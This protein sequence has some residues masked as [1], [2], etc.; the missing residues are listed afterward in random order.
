MLFL[1]CSKSCNK[2]GRNRDRRSH[3]NLSTTLSYYMHVMHM[4]CKHFMCACSKTSKNKQISARN[5]AYK[6]NLCHNVDTIP[7]WLR[8]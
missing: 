4:E 7:A 5:Q 1:L 8:V 3:D 2:P 6:P